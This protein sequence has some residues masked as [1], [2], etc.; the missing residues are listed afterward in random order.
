MRSTPGTS[1]AVTLLIAFVAMSLLSG[2]LFAGLFIPAVGASASITK[3]SVTYFNSLPADMSRPPLA[4][5]STMYASDGTTVIARFYDENRVTVPL[6]RIAPVMREAIIAVE[7]SRF[8]QH[9]GIDP[10]G[11]LRAFV[12]NQVG[13]DVQGASTLTQQYIKNYNV[14]KCVAAG[15]E[16]CARRAVAKNEARK[17]QEMRMA[18]ALEKQLSKDEILEGYLNIALFGDNTFGVEA[19]S[20]YYFNT[21]AS[22]LT[23]VQA[24]TLAGLVQSPSTYSP[25]QH[26]EAAVSRRNEVLSRMLSLDMITQEQYEEAK[27]TELTTD[28]HVAQ[29]G[30][31][32]AGNMAF[33]CDYVYRTLQLDPAYSYLGKTEAQRRTAIKRG[34]YKII[35]TLDPAL[36]KKSAALVEKQIPP[37]DP[38]KL[39]AAAVVVQPGTGKVLAM[40]QNRTYST[41]SKRGATSINYAVDKAY[42]SSTGFSTGSTFKPFTL[43]TWLSEGKS[44]RDVVDASEP[45]GGRPFSDFTACGERLRGQTYHFG[46]AE[47]GGRGPMTVLNATASSVNTAYVD[48][49]S[50]LDLCDIVDTATKLGVHLASV[51]NEGSRCANYSA[52]NPLVLPNC[53][54][55]LT[56]GPLSIS[57]LTMATAYATFAADGKFCEAVP[58]AGITNS[59]GEPQAVTEQTCNQAIT[60][61][62]SRGV[63]YALKKALANG[64]GRGLSIGK[65]AAGKT[66][67]ADQSSNTW[68]VGYTPHFSTA[69]W[70][71]DPNTY[72]GH[73]AT[74]GQRPLH[75]IT[76]NG[77]Y[78]GTIYGATLAGRIWSNIMKNASKDKPS[79]DWSGPP[80]SMFTTN[81]VSVPDV[82]GDNVAVAMATLS[83]SGFQVKN[84]GIVSSS[85][86]AGSVAR[87]SPS[88][89]SL[90]TRGA[91]VTIYIS[92]GSQHDGGGDG[93]LPVIPGRGED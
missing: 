49:E 43:A 66:G 24:A 15:D 7:D 60:A 39:A 47:G 91:T 63:T 38:S 23:L 57:P 6:S 87:M 55:S 80:G 11:L 92:D 73:S 36:Q 14:E 22:K 77:R 10:K 51:P 89:G 9:G 1:R 81:G 82:V 2:V 41:E 5:Q 88:G 79:T 50:R 33:F 18:I 19:A 67:T 61:E 64:T 17:L 84:G 59:A 25:F 48:M 72:P 65:P 34:G 31:I 53:F 93:D 75:G 85:E 29:N 68:Y 71:A 52:D 20:E 78:Y 16:E 70:V 42:G 56:L 69:V 86:P 90:S 58:V 26:P 54:P 32:T 62:V 83:R 27:V 8:Y 4:E 3:S 37:K 76:V 12:N 45:A 46:N 30:C 21:S 74:S 28:K 44:L 13:G 35:T 40:T